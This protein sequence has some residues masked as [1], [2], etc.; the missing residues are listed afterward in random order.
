MV[1]ALAVVFLYAPW[2]LALRPWDYDILRAG[3]SIIAGIGLVAVFG[4]TTYFS[5]KDPDIKLLEPANVVSDDEVL[6]LLSQ[7]AGTP[8]VG[9]VASQAIEQINSSSRKRGR[10]RKIVSAQFSEGSLSWDKFSGLVDMA[11]RTVLRNAALVAN[12]LQSFD[13]EGYSR[14][15]RHKDAQTEQLALYDKSLASMREALEANERI[16]LEMG[17]LELELGTL[18]ADDTRTEADQTIEELRG[19]IEETR[20]Y[21]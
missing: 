3:F 2:A 21:R 16:L 1:I 14:A 13:Q 6:P 20:Y 9:D 10:L 4:A 17:K 5:L 12:G 7:Y 8:F 19:L 15:R 18:E 11:V